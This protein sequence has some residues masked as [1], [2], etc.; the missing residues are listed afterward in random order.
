MRGIIVLSD[1]WKGR[2][3]LLT[4]HTGFVG[5]WLSCVLNEKGADVT[6]FSLEEEAGSLYGKIKKNLF[7]TS[8]YG[9][10]RNASEIRKCVDE[11]NP[12]IVFH[13]AAFGFVKECYEEPE[14]AYSC[15]V[16]GTVNLLNALKNVGHPVKIVVASS[17]KV[18]LNSGQ[19][20]YLF[21]ESD[22]LGGSDSYSA[23]KTC[24]DLAARSF[25]EMYLKEKGFSMCIVRPSNI[26]GGG[27]HIMTRLIPS[28]YKSISRGERPQIRNP[29]S[30]R[31]WQHILDM[32]DAYLTLAEKSGN[33]LTIFNIGPEPD[34]IKTV[35]EISDYVLH[36]YGLD[37]K[38]EHI[39]GQAQGDIEKAYLGLS[40]EKVKTEIGWSPRKSLEETLEDIYEFYTM[41]HGCTAYG[42]CISQIRDY[43]K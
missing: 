27:D 36:L 32:T 7:I 35:R 13:I 15:N 28:I 20:A 12:E 39:R 42:L 24:E 14:R 25:F 5:A 23:S 40:I 18:Y 22:P 26:L 43:Y 19:E 11:C 4:G 9:D 38:N 31:P 30:I 8:V 41:D 17:D 2:K 37:N 29:S 16:M 33:G 1:Y 10:L 21:S 3:V 6:G 34:G